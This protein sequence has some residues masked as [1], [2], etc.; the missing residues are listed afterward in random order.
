MAKRSLTLYGRMIQKR[1]I[2]KGMTQVEL[3]KY[4]GCDPGYLCQILYGDRTG[5][6]YRE[7]ISKLLDIETVA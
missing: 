6:K 3:A 1:L 4:L 5:T 7:K 2:D